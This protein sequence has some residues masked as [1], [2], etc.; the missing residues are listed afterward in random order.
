MSARYDELKSLKN[1][2]Q[3]YGY[4]DREVM[5]YAYGIGLAL[6]DARPMARSSG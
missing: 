6:R 4:T 2:G 1:L 3:K 5:L